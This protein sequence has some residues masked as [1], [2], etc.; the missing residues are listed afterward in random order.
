MLIRNRQTDALPSSITPTQLA[1]A[2][3][4]L[5]LS[6]IP[7]HKRPQAIRDH[8]MRIMADTIHDRTT[9]FE[10]HASRLLRQKQA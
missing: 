8:L 2:M 4:Q 5:D 7:E 3:Q 6:A 10:I 9:A 1:Q